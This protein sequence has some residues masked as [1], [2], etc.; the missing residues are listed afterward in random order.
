MVKLQFEQLGKGI[1]NPR[2]GQAH[3][4][5]IHHQGGQYINQVPP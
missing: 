3:G 4:W 1:W 5:V 2:D